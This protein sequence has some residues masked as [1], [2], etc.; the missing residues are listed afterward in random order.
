M[1]EVST[2][3]R[4]AVGRL[5]PGGAAVTVAGFAVNLLGYVVPLL[6]ARL[7]TKDDNGA[8]AAALALLAVVAVPALGL[9][10]ALAVRWARDGR[11][12]NAAAATAATTAVTAGVLVVATPVISA[13]L[14]LSP[15]L[16]LLLV[17]ITAAAI[18]GSRWLGQLQGA[19]RFGRL[20]V[21][22]VLLAVSRYGGIIVGLVLGA[23]VTGALVVGAVVAW[24]TLPVLM[25]LAGRAPAA[26][27]A[28]PT[29]LQGR[30]IVA[31]S[32]ATLA[33]LAVSYADLIL[34]R[35]LLPPAQAGEYA[36]GA[37][38]TKGALWAPQVVTI[39]ALPR[40]A[41]G[42][43][44]ALVAAL[45]VVAACGAVL[46]LASLFAGDLAIWLAGGPDYAGMSGYAAGFAAVGALYALVFVL[47]NAEIAARVRFPAAPLWVALA[48]LTVTAL[49]LDP[50]A[51]GRLLTLSICTAALTTVAMGVVVA[52]N[53]RV[54]AS[55]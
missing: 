25:A 35:H 23:G 38:L 54:L 19:E 47:V 52:R 15:V 44:R 28:T 27:D 29:R 22:M 21:G 36:V 41:Q 24:L 33:M 31:A 26:P 13:A 51:V 14:H 9:Q 55:G 32:G 7:L 11:V 20:A 17:A 48:G 2:V 8:L 49:L 3:D 40:L 45:A 12:P 37:V 4:T 50:S 6:G 42:S 43:R 16:P 30:D 34:A 10:T 46:V 18:V 39:L 5:G 1:P 53:S